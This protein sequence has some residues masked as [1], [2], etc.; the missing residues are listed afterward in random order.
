MIGILILL[1][2]AYVIYDDYKR[3]NKSLLSKLKKKYGDVK[4]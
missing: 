3:P 1:A 2:V 4:E